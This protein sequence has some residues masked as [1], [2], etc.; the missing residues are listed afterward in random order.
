[1]AKNTREYNREYQRRRRVSLQARGLCNWCGKEDVEIGKNF[2]TECLV[3]M[4]KRSFDKY[5][6]DKE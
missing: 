1:M 4:R 5:W 2:C 3:L 6:S